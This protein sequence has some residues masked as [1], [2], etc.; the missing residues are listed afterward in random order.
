[1]IQLISIIIGAFI[2]I[3]IGGFFVMGVQRLMWWI[4]NKLFNR[5]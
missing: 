3:T 2:V 4:A 1:M 5:D